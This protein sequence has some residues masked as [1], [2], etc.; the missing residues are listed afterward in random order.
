MITDSYP[1]LK[2][3]TFQPNKNT[4]RHRKCMFFL[5]KTREEA[6]IP[7]ESIWKKFTLKQ[8]PGSCLPGR[9]LLLWSYKPWPFTCYNWQNT[10]NGMH[11][12]A[13]ITQGNYFMFA[14]PLTIL[15]RQYLFFLCDIIHTFFF[16][17]TKVKKIFEF[18]YSQVREYYEPC[19]IIT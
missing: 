4:G 8:T 5:E 16:L 11:E 2:F 3:W 17:Y 1:F 6:I 15:K 18:S 7:K 14:Q 9:I 12:F 19:F 10:L 13:H